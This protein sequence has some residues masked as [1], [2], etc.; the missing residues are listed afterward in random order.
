MSHL[1]YSRQKAEKGSGASLLG[2]AACSA[3]VEH[4]E[5]RHIARGLVSRVAVLARVHIW[6]Q[7][8]DAKWQADSGKRVGPARVTRLAR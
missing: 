4:R 2:R 6:T 1:Q 7:L 3:L 5:A 8:D